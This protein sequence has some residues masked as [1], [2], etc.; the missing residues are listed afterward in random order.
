M[1]EAEITANIGLVHLCARRLSSR[2]IPYE[3]LC[4]AG[5][6]GLC[7]AARGFDPARGYAFATYAVPVILGEMRRLFR[8]S[9]GV[10]ISRGMQERAAR[11]KKS[12]EH[13]RQMHHREP[14]VREIAAATG[15]SAAET[16]EALCAAQ[17]LVSMD[18]ADSAC[19]DIPVSSPEQAITEHLALRQALELLAPA[20]RQLIA[21]RYEQGM[22]QSAAAER[23]HMTQVQVSRR[24]RKILQF[25]RT[26]LS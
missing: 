25:L 23:L 13:L 22:T 17:P 3:E 9:G 8:E 6:L 21:L 10:R 19:M 20:D 5:N 18:A 4:S 2:G 14:T 26:E 1:T 11:A 12:A 16:A 7:K 24:E 15:E